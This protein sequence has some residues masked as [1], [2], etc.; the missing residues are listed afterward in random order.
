MQ[1]TIFVIL[2]TANQESTKIADSFFLLQIIWK[3]PKELK[4]N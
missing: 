4:D 2:A 3:P 1:A